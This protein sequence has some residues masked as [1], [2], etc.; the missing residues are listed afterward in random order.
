MSTSGKKL[1]P[2]QED[3]LLIE[4]TKKLNNINPLKPIKI[5]NTKP[6]GKRNN[7]LN[8]IRNLGKAVKC[9]LFDDPNSDLQFLGKGVASRVYLSCFNAECK[10][11]VAVRLMSI[12]NSLMYNN[13]HP[14][15]LEI[16]AYNKF[17]SLLTKNITAHLPYKIKNFQCSI[18]YLSK[19]PIS[20]AITNIKPC[21]LMEKL[22]VILIF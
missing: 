20:D 4:V 12:D 11:R 7:V 2:P 16:S 14:N 10:R 8:E 22:K 9:D 15:K 6:D 5:K 19:T 3:V 17:N 21:I 18:N 13:T 1:N